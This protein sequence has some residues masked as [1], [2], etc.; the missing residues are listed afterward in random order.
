MIEAWGLLTSKPIRGNH[1][2]SKDN[3]IG[4]SQEETLQGI[5]AAIRVLYVCKGD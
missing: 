4:P 5:I 1:Y 2:I 3:S